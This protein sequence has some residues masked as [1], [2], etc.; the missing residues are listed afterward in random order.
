MASTNF[1]LAP[2][3]KTVDGLLAVPIDIQRITA[4][5]TFN[6]AN[7]TGTG[8]ASVE[9]IMGPDDGNPV[10]DLRQ[11]ITAVWLDSNPVAVAKVAHHDFGGGAG[12]EM[13]ILEQVLAAGSAHALRVTYSL[14]TPQAS[15]AGSYQ[16]AMTWSSGP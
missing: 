6:G 7:Q 10:F 8:D 12:A 5:L 9:F 3:S 15:G 2:A 13:R 11:T 4:T 14:G 16:P 1:D